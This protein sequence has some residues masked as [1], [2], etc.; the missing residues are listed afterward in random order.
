MRRSWL[1]GAL[2]LAAPMLPVACVDSDGTSDAGADA[3]SDAKPDARP[4]ATA[5]A[6]VDA[7]I[8]ASADVVVPPSDASDA[9]DAPEVDAGPPPPYALFV[10]TN[11]VSSGELVAVVHR[12][13]ARA[14]GERT[15][16]DERDHRPHARQRRRPHVQL[17]AVLALRRQVAHD[18]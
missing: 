4:D 15:A 8:D 6:G 12:V 18:A 14:G 16:V 11:F 9:A 5:D 2:L 7:T 1:V 10:G 17:Q 3:T 13:L